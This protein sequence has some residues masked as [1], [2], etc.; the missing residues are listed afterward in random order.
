MLPPAF[1]CWESPKREHRTVVVRLWVLSGIFIVLVVLE[2]LF[3]S[4]LDDHS[5]HYLES[6]LHRCTIKWILN[7]LLLLLS[8]FLVSLSLHLLFK[9]NTLHFFILCHVWV[10]DHPLSGFDGEVGAVRRVSLDSFFSE[11]E[12]ECLGGSFLEVE[13]IS[14]RF[15]LSFV[16]TLHYIC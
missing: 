9:I 16:I 3:I 2:F 13:L 4:I 14:Q 15:L 7:M 11:R 12:V 10:E 5:L 1:V 8:V 6:S